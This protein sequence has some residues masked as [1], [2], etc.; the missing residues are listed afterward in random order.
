MKRG[1]TPTALYKGDI[2]ERFLGED[3]EGFAYDA[4]FFCYPC[5]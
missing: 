5:E 3:F 4:A 2:K 1:T